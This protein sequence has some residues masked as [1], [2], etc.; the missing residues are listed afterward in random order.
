MGEGISTV[1]IFKIKHRAESQN[2]EIP[3]FSSKSV[4]Q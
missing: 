2:I 3:R 1:E 4:S